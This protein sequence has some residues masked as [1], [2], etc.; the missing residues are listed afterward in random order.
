TQ[1]A[2][3]AELL[4]SSKRLLLMDIDMIPPD[5]RRNDPSAP[6]IDAPRRNDAAPVSA[7][8]SQMRCG[9]DAVA[10]A[11]SGDGR[12]AR[13]EGG[14][15]EGGSKPDPDRGREQKP[16]EYRQSRQGGRLGRRQR[17]GKVDERA[18][19][20]VVVGDRRRLL[21]RRIDDCLRNDRCMS[22]RTAL[23]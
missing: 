14:V 15:M 23:D 18:D 3:S 17:A 13:A 7:P 21:A 19:R 2:T 12:R 20:A 16:A 1:S 9:T 10:R 4:K 22:G 5:P 8:R 6:N 11:M